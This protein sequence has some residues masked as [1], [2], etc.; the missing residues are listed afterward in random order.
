[1][2]VS[3]LIPPTLN[4]LSMAEAFRFYRDEL[5]WHVYPVDG[6]WSDKPDPGKKPSVRAWWKYDSRKCDLAQY[7]RLRRCHDIGFA[8]SGKIIMIDLDSKKDKGESVYRFL[9]SGEL[10]DR[11]SRQ[12][13]P[14]R[15]LAA[16]LHQ[17]EESRILRGAVDVALF[18]PDTLE[19]SSKFLH[20]PRGLGGEGQSWLIEGFPNRVQKLGPDPRLRIAG[21]SV[22]VGQTSGSR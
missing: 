11:D 17:A 6:P 19:T 8:P 14:R 16:K 13:R 5:N 9:A 22:Q 12:Y 3:R 7:F 21:P 10:T 2:N 15:C 1:M 18:C 20:L 4:N